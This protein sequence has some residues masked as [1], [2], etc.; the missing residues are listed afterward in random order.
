MEII[1][2][3]AFIII[4]GYLLLVAGNLSPNSVKGDIV[5]AKGFPTF[6][7]AL[8]L[9][10]SIIILFGTI[11]KTGNIKFKMKNSAKG[12]TVTIVVLGVWL[13]IMNVVGFVISTALFIFANAALM[14]YKKYKNLAIFTIVLTAALVLSFGKLFFVPLPRGMGLFRELSYYLY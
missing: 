9:L 13:S 3:I 12:G 6:V 4:M 10:L 7:I 8:A 11:R 1:F 5:T 2:N 14:G